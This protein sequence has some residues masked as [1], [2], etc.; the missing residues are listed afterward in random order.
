MIGQAIAQS[1]KEANFKKALD[2][3]IQSWHNFLNAD[4]GYI[5][6]AIYQLSAAES[7]VKAAKAELEEDHDQR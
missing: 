4:S 3:F 2:D 7:R 5:D 1:N 6:S